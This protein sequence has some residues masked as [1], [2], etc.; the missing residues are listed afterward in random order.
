MLCVQKAVERR[1][2]PL[3]HTVRP[4]P[5]AACVSEIDFMSNGFN[6]LVVHVCLCVASGPVVVGIYLKSKA[7]DATRI[8]NCP[9]DGAIVP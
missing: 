6:V 2:P 3:L 5:P 4:S 1:L 7:D 8:L 9:V